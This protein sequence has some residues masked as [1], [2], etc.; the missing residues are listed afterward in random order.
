MKIKNIYFTFLGL[1]I[2]NMSFAG[3]FGGS[4]ESAIV[5]VL[6]NIL[7]LATGSIMRAVFMLFIVGCL[8]LAFIN[9]LDWSYA[10]KGCAAAGGISAA[11]EIGRFLLNGVF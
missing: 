4:G 11:G 6:E 8:Y 1:L 9:R 7:S 2:S 5:I 10:V 3:R